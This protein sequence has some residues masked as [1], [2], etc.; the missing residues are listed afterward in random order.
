MEGKEGKRKQ[1]QMD[2]EKVNHKM[3]NL[4]SIIF[5][6]TLNGNGH[7]SQFKSRHPDWIK[8]WGPNY[9]LPIRNPL[10]E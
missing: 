4:N 8:N 3:A 1:K 10:K 9:M 5:I 6:I 2:K 7:I